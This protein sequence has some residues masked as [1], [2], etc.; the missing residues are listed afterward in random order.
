MFLLNPSGVLFGPNAALDI[1]GSFHVT[2]A[3]YIRF[4]DGGMFHANL[5]RPTLLSVAPPAA[6][7][8]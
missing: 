5:A 7:G 6:F 8:S 3:D 4:P 2:T 1:G